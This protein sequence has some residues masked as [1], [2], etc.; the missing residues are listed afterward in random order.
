M[1]CRFVSVRPLRSVGSGGEFVGGL[2][3]RARV[4]L[5]SPVREHGKGL[6]G[7]GEVLLLRYSY[8]SRSV[9]MVNSPVGIPTF[10]TRPTTQPSWRA[11]SPSRD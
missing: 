4:A 9:S 8:L 2:V 7:A 1:V 11:R 3:G 6:D 10:C 5:D